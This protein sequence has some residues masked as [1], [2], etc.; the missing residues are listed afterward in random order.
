[1]SRASSVVFLLALSD[2][3]CCSSLPQQRPAA[4]RWFD[5]IDDARLVEEMER[6]GSDVV[7]PC[8]K[9][10]PVEACASLVSI[11]EAGAKL[12]EEDA[13]LRGLVQ[14]TAPKVY[15]Q[16]VADQCYQTAWGLRNEG[17]E[18]HG[19][20]SDVDVDIDAETMAAFR[21][22]R[23]FIPYV[24][25]V[26]SGIRRGSV[27]PADL[28]IE[29]RFP[30]S[31]PFTLLLPYVGND[32]KALELAQHGSTVGAVIAGQRVTRTA[33]A[34]ATRLLD[35][36]V[37]NPEQEGK[38]DDRKWRL[39]AD[40]NLAACGICRALAW[41]SGRKERRLVAINFSMAGEPPP[42]GSGPLDRVLAQAA[43]EKNV[44]VVVAAGNR[45]TPDRPEYPASM[46]QGKPNVLI[47]TG[48]DG[49]GAPAWQN[50]GPW[51]NIAAPG[52]SILTYQEGSKTACAGG[53]SLAA[54]FVAG[55]ASLLA[56]QDPGR[57]AGDIVNAIMAGAC[58]TYWRTETAYRVP[59]PQVQL[60]ACRALFPHLRTE[61]GICACPP[62][63]SSDP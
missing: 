15:A 50:T 16:D 55:T 59:F 52:R 2:I 1:M 18:K 26:D 47:V 42:A 19:Y 22:A 12:I 11:S 21:P 48:I 33:V 8:T 25:V 61:G 27:L 20:R 4:R 57:G 45:Q 44:V 54:P 5:R 34:P 3:G 62:A 7:E 13:G 23:N 6:R 53:T 56:A 38:G 31:E 28:V 51:I 24:A 30:E 40:D 9:V 35:V 37:A 41:S 14:V 43:K 60:N 58:P 32:A 29:S 17:L 49:R 46:L 39:G 63:P 10:A 36:H